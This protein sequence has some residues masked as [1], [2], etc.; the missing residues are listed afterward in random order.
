MSGTMA[1]TAIAAV[2]LAGGCISPV[3]HPLRVRNGP[4]AQASF[5]VNLPAS[6]DKKPCPADGCEITGGL[7]VP[8]LAPGWGRVVGDHFGVM[9]GLSFPAWANQQGR[10]WFHAASLW[11][12]LTL[13]NEHASIGVGPEIGAGGAAITVG[14]EVKPW[15]SWNWWPT[16]GVYGRYYR[17]FSPDSSATRQGRKPGR[18]ASAWGS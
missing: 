10:R 17:P 16:L 12:F 11:S 1:P 2:L 3:T 13:Q 6:K 15:P 5:T 14:G 7:N 4:V 9:G 8:E 18:L